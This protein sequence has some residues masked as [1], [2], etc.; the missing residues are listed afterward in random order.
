MVESFEDRVA[1]GREETLA[2]RARSDLA[3][4]DVVMGKRKFPDVK[5]THL[6]V[7]EL[8]GLARAN[9]G[10]AMFVSCHT[11]GYYLN[12]DILQ[13]YPVKVSSVAAQGSLDLFKRIDYQMPPNITAL[14]YLSKDR[15]KNIVSGKENLSI[16]ADVIFPDYSNCTVKLL[17]R[18]Y[19]Y[20]VTWAELAIRYKLAVVPIFSRYVDDQLEVRMEWMSPQKASVAG[21]AGDFFELF[22]E[23]LDGNPD[24]WENYPLFREFSFP[25][26]PIDDRLSPKML[27]AMT[28]LGMCD[29]DVSKALKGL[30]DN[31][32]DL[33]VESGLVE[34]VLALLDGTVFLPEGAMPAR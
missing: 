15:M 5:F 12:N 10:K 22:D 3:F 32:A 4:S 20:T 21:L 17:G 34:E 29:K 11:Y 23:F 24:I 7:E 13:G 6:C 33:S 16:M 1:R 28:F 25:M 30:V 14:P 8:S 9:D 2:R 27:Q 19:R 18:T 26:L 31:Q